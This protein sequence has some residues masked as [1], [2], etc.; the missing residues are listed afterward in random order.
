M[1]T[2]SLGKRLVWG[3]ALSALSCASTAKADTY[4]MDIVPNSHFH[5]G[6]WNF[7]GSDIVPTSTTQHDDFL[8][9]LAWDSVPSVRH[10]HV[11]DRNSVLLIETI[12]QLTSSREDTSKK[13]AAAAP[14]TRAV[15]SRTR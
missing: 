15:R 1:F 13:E 6:G 10:P 14:R 7:Y 9:R 11:D 4:G 5:Q 12:Q 8:N 3:V 2:R